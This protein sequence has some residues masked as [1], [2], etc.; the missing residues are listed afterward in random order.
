MW[1]ASRVRS[2]EFP[3]PECRCHRQIDTVYA[4]VCFS[5]LAANVCV[6]HIYLAVLSTHGRHPA[7]PV[8]ML[9]LPLKAVRQQ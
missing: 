1:E 3:F 8:S 5:H 2:P 4:D 9:I 6:L 7:H